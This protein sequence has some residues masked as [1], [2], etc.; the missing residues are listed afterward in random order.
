MTDDLSLPPTGP[1]RRYLAL[2]LPYLS[3]DRLHRQML[4]K[5]WRCAR[6]NANSCRE[7][8]SAGERWHAD[9]DVRDIT[10]PPERKRLGGG[11]P[12]LAI[13][14][15]IES[16]LRLVAL[17]ENAERLG[18]QIGQPLAD[19][20]AMIPTLGV[21]DD[22]PA[23]DAGLLAAIADWAE[24]YTPLVALDGANGLMLDITGCAHLFG[25][26]EAL[27]A[28]LTRRIAEQGF[29][30]QAAIADTPG[31]ASAA[32]RF[33]RLA[34][35]PHGGAREML[36]P[37]PL[38]ALRLDGEIVSAMDRVGLKKIGQILDAPRAPLAAR[39]GMDLIRKLD[40]ALGY[41]EE[42][43][44]PRR[45][46]PAF[47]AERRFAEPIS[48]EED[49][50]ATLSS[51]AATLATSLE[52]HAEGARHLEFS[53]FRVDGLVTRIA[54]GAGRPIRAPKLIL[55][56][57]REKFVSLGDEIDAGFGFDM[58]R[59]SVTVSAAADPTQIDLSG[60][61]GAEA[62][63]DALI[64]RI[65]ARLGEESVSAIVT[66]ESH[67]PER[68]EILATKGKEQASAGDRGTRGEEDRRSDREANN[69]SL[70]RPLRLFT[71]PEP[72]EAIAEVP[73]GP[74]VHFR[75]RRALYRIAR[76]EGP[77]RIAAEWWRDDGL[78]RDY[79]RVED[80]A[81]HRFW[82]YREGLYGRE[83]ITPRWF[84]HGVFA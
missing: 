9:E 64:D 75:W 41:D 43:I 5:S 40:Q 55:A 28:D 50:A 65:G 56:L 54:V 77:E 84:L 7:R 18:L 16:A 51:L 14:A 10:P 33:T 25:G 3:T 57:F 44:S 22:D 81:G 82:L 62:D 42:A 2:S 32:A 13:V 34:V 36:T 30:P 27:I 47:I 29:P 68:A 15:K 6:G 35:V 37:L 45:P 78:T 8:P 21:T 61:A 48:R 1:P 17:D 83:L 31:A 67:I 80:S 73:D 72:V 23:A 49:I 60:D 19:A 11:Q 59:L 4:G 70:T 46:P 20:R 24:R 12:P 58:A 63:L 66:R 26:E 53:L 38:A 74:P 52:A 79:F 71:R 39:F 69:S 76:A